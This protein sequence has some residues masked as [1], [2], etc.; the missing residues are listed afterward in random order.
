VI[1]LEAVAYSSY[2]HTGVVLVGLKLISV[3]N[4]LPSVLLHCCLGHLTCKNRPRN[5]LLSVQWDIKPLFIT[6]YYITNVNVKSTAI[7]LWIAS[8]LGLWLGSRNIGS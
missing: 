2:C 1:S 7:R 3:A 8:V 5:D 4:W 6:H